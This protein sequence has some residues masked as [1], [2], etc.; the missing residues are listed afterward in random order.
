MSDD[1]AVYDFLRT[2]Q[3][4][5]LRT[6]KEQAQRLI[7]LGEELIRKIERDG[8]NGYYSINHDCLAAARR[9]HGTCN[10]LWRLRVLI[11]EIDKVAKNKALNS[12]TELEAPKAPTRKSKRRKKKD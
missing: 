3:L 1:S 12:S 6:A 5:S 8:L 2:Q 9:V 11:E 10:E 7:D 4:W